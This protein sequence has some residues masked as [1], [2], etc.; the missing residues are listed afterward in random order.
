MSE[1]DLVGWKNSKGKSSKRACIQFGPGAHDLSYVADDIT[2]ALEMYTAVVSVASKNA[3]RARG[4][5]MQ[6]MGGSCG[7]VLYVCKDEFNAFADSGIWYVLIWMFEEQEMWIVNATG[8]K[9]YN[10]QHDEN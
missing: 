6:L 3:T 5:V 7:V 4:C 10:T 2:V 9:Q 8:R 1:S